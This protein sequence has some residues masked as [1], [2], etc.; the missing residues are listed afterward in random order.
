MG[1]FLKISGAVILS[2]M[3]FAMA[4]V[5]EVLRIIL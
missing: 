1:K 5:T 4:L 2:V 3:M